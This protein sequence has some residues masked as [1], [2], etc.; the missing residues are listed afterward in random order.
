[1][2]RIPCINEPLL[3]FGLLEE[4]SQGWQVSEVFRTMHGSGQRVIRDLERTF[5]R[6]PNAEGK[7]LLVHLVP[8]SCRR[9]HRFLLWSAARFI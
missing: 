8:L 1:M 5:T 3:P 2:V 6:S 4:F 7:E 9:C